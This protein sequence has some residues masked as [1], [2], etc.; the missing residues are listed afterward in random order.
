MVKAL[1]E[2]QNNSH[3]EKKILDLTG[4]AS[5]VKGTVILMLVNCRGKKTIHCLFYL[6]VGLYG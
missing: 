6:D 1:K 4:R 5:K 2:D 3:M